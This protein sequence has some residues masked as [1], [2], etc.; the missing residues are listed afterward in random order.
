VPQELVAFAGI[1]MPDKFFQ[2]LKNMGANLKA[3]YCFADHYQ[4]SPSDIWLMV[5]KHPNEE[6]WTTEKD[7]VRLPE[8]LKPKVKFLPVKI[9]FDDRENFSLWLTQALANR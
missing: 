8:A 9:D 1:G 4:Y 7:Y 2:T 3:A 6:L 5:E